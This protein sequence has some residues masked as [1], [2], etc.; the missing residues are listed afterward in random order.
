VDRMQVYL[1][2]GAVCG[3]VALLAWG[4][5]RL[6]RML[7]DVRMLSVENARLRRQLY[8]FRNSAE[9]DLG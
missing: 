6:R 4:W 8:H 2:G 9:H 1:I 7:S 3:I 5:S